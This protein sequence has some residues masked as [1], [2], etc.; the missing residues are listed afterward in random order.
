MTIRE[1]AVLATVAGSLLAP[2]S[3]QA[4]TGFLCGEEHRSSREARDGRWE[5]ASLLTGGPMYAGDPN[6]E[7]VIT[8]TIQFGTDGRT[9]AGPDAATASSP[10][11]TG[12]AFLPSTPVHYVK[13]PTYIYQCTQV[14]VNGVTYYYDDLNGA[15]SSSPDVPCYTWWDEVP[16]G[17][18]DDEVDATAC[19][20]PPLDSAVCDWSVRCEPDEPWG[21]AWW[22]VLYRPV[23]TLTHCEGN[24][25]P[26]R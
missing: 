6:A 21:W 11:G 23:E 1:L 3:A 7:I 4:Q 20:L 8:C 5:H 16:P 25:P 15:W 17:G 2:S 13:E 22:A 9:H 26:L 18:L 12:V 24:L 19:S 14:T 10:V